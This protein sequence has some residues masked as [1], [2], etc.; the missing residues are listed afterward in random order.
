MESAKD[1]AA[2]AREKRIYELSQVEVSPGGTAAPEVKP[3]QVPFRHLCSLVQIADGDIERTMAALTG[4]EGGPG[5]EQLPAVRAR[6]LCA[7]YWIE[8]YAPQE[9][10]F[11][12]RS[13]GEK[14]DLS[15]ELAAGVRELRDTV[16][17]CIE[18]YRDDKSCAE[19]IYRAA[20]KTGIDAKALFRASYQAL[21][22]KDQGPRLAN[23]L[24][25]VDKDRLLD[26][27]AIY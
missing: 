23:F 24:R 25:T 9:F 14:A 5:E 16:V 27:L 22:G 12:L 18:T 11:R 26:I 13:P 10:R 2:F 17:A 15:G 6:V 8:R 4:A 20:E 21:I 7:K 19:A 1:E 3:W